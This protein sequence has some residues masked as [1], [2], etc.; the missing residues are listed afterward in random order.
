MKAK[1]NF[2]IKAYNDVLT[3]GKYKGKSV[4]WILKCDPSY[5]IW[6]THKEII[7]VSGNIY[8]DARALHEYDCEMKAN[9]FSHLNHNYSVYYDD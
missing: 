8:T 1:S 5:I 6:I 9:A 2:T 7:P 4:G 3:F